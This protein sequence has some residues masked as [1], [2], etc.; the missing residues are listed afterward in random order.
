AISGDTEYFC[1][2]CPGV[3]SDWPSKCPV[4]NMALV[5]R[6]KGEMAALPDGVVSRMQLSPYRIQLAGIKTSPLEFGP[7]YHEVHCA[8]AFEENSPRRDGRS[9]IR[10]SSEVSHEDWPLLAVG[11]EAEATGKMVPGRPSFRGRVVSL[12]DPSTAGPGARIVKLEFDD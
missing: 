11:Q 10:I 4:C 1:P 12:G 5:R 7:L 8:G 3:L 2:M 6:K 9:R